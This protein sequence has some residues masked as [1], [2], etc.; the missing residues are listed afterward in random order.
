MNK[1]VGIII[2]L[3]VIIGG[4]YLLMN[5]T[6]ATIDTNNTKQ[7]P[8]TGAVSQGRVIFSVTDAAVNMNTISEIEMTVNSVA[9]QSGTSGWVTVS[10]TPRT[11]N[12]LE[13]N[14]SGESKL[15][16]DINTNTGTYNQIRLMVDS[17]V[18]TTSTGAKREATLPSGELRI[19]TA[20]LV[21]ENSTTS[22]NLDFLADKS[23]HA[24][25]TGQFIFSPVVKT[26]SRSNA[27]VDIDASGNVT[28]AGGQVDDNRT[29]GMDIDG[30]VK[31]DFQIPANQKLNIDTNNTIKL[32]L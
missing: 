12:L 31:L 11:Y 5:R 16:A 2:A 32:E 20:M 24:T 25:G 6:P 29:V 26:E 8:A 10:T 7:E 17:I 21:N 18:V 27:N 4:G 22:V 15:L 3:V 28:I 23:L 14:E 13:L 30:S 19:N 1:T 9:I